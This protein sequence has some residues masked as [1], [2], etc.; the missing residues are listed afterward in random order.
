MATKKKASAKPAAK[1]LTA[2]RKKMTKSDVVSSIADETGLTKKDVSAVFAT[3]GDLI[4][5]HMKRNG[6]GEFHIPDTG[7]KIARIKKPARKSRMGR[8]P[9]TGES[10]KIAAKPAHTAVKVTALKAL[11]D[12]ING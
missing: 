4:T 5:R 8:N 1:K 12:T 11:K 7:V 2:I 3:L 6:S 10:I 9:A